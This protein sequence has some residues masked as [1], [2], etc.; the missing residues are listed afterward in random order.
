[1]FCV[2]MLILTQSAVAQV[3]INE[4]IA[5]NDNIIAD[6]YNEYD[7]IIEI[8]NAGNTPI[9]LAGYYFSDDV[10]LPLM[11]QVPTTNAVLTTVPA[12]GYLIF[13]ADNET[14]QGENHLNFKLSSSGESIR[15]TRPDEVTVED[16]FTFPAINTDEAYGRLPDGSNNLSQLLPAS[17]AQ[18]ND[19]SL[20]QTVPPVI[21]PQSGL[22][23]NSQN[24]SISAEP[25]TSIYYT[26]D[27]STPTL[28]SNLYSA[29]FAIDSSQSIKAVAL[30][31][32]FGLSNVTS[33]A[34][35]FNTNT[36]LDILNVSIDPDLLWS[37]SLGIYVTGTNG[38]EGPCSETVPRNWHQNWEYQAEITLFNKNGEVE[39]KEGCGLSISGNC[40]RNVEKKSFAV[41]FKKV[42]GAGTLEHKLFEESEAMEWDGFMLRSGGNHRRNGRINDR[43]AQRVFENQLNIDLQYS[44]PVALYL[45]GE[46]WGLYNI[47]DRSNSGYIKTHHPK[48]DKDSL[49]LI[50][51]PKADGSW[52][53]TIAE[54]VKEGDNIA[55]YDWYDYLVNN[56]LS[57]PANYEYAIS[58]I[59][60]ESFMDYLVTNIYINNNDWPGKNLK[61]WRERIPEGKWRWLM[62][63]LDHFVP[64][65]FARTSNI[66]L[67]DEIMN[68][69]ATNTQRNPVACQPIRQLMANEVFKSEFIQR[70]NTYMATVWDSTRSAAILNEIIAE[71]GN[72]IIPDYDKWGGWDYDTWLSVASNYNDFFEL[73][74]PYMRQMI[75]SV[76]GTSGRFDL[77]LNFDNASNG[78]VALHSNH[79]EVPYSFIAKYHANVPIDIH[80]I[81]NPGYRFSHWEETGNTNSTLYQSFNANTTLTPVFEPALDVVIN[82]IHYHPNDSTNQKEFIEIYNPD[83]KARN[84]SGYEFSEGI[85]FKFPRATTIAPNEYIVIATDVSQYED[86]AYQVFQW[87][88]SKLDNDGENL[89]LQNPIGAIIDSVQYNDGIPWALLADGFGHS[90]ELDYP[91][92]TDNV[93]PADWHASSP[94]DGTPGA[95]NSSPCINS[96]QEI[97]INEINYNSSDSPTPGDWIEL[98]NP[99]STSVDLSDWGF[100]DSENTFDIPA[101]TVLQPDE[102]LVLVE[103]VSLFAG[104]FPH[105]NN[106]THYIGNFDFNLSGGGERISLL[107]NNKCLSDELTY[108]DDMPWDTIP[109]GNGPSL[110]LITTNLDN[111]LPQSWETSSNINSTYGTPARPN[112]PC[113]EQQITVVDTI[114][115]GQATLLRTDL[116]INNTNYTWLAF[117]ATL[118]DANADSTYATWNTPGSYNI[119]L[120]TNYFE[121]TKIYN[122]QVTVLQGCTN[123]DFHAFLE[124]PYDLIGGEMN[125]SS[126]TLHGLLPGQTPTNDL[127]NPT[128]PGHPYSIPPW[129]Y[130]G[131]EGNNWTNANYTDNVVDWVLVSTRTELDKNTQAG[132]AAGLINKDGSIHFWEG[133]P[134]ESIGLDSV[135]VVI[136]HR[137]HMGIMTPQKIPVIN[138][139][140]S[141][142]FRFS[143]SYKDVTSVGQKEILPGVWAMFAGDAD[144]S[145]FPSFDIKGTDKTLWLN[146]NGIF[147]QYMIP[148]FDLNGDVNGADKALW[149]ENNGVSSRVPK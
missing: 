56:D 101:G 80:A 47:R 29:P 134:L 91:L 15:L 143:D 23:T 48:A 71:V 53:W 112:T 70:P 105:L 133:C 73:R 5:S 139:S 126:N 44:R 69:T 21:S 13:W 68:G 94:I 81:P 107:D 6:N 110:S 11:W 54:E 33:T 31:S 2:S 108:D 93:N 76:L 79:F 62:F 9:N 8:Y 86:N 124:G 55:Y 16:S 89:I 127:V 121:C 114:Y 82:E 26:T 72:E 109:D 65:S 99:G 90:L 59:D 123:T 74:P 58:K 61:V 146:N 1:M 141:W 88:K 83:I 39:F 84:L 142:D 122:H 144:Q 10:N 14:A 106:E 130:T 148:D 64:Q 116:L 57:I 128:P 3:Y 4:I 18:S 129:N 34:Y 24:L 137:N 42:F 52:K 32:G 117:G 140:L 51:L 17:P 95:Q 75:D 92:P 20:P 40:S 125:T 7:D 35:I 19:S 43:F 97:V 67:L 119:Q 111:T 98:Y 138:N 135:Y 63:D 147:Q 12:G 30:K 27:G 104:I 22:Y 77:T 36:D 50:S 96:T 60:F 136:E 103:D 131:T 38:I 113:P 115:S 87:E 145:D 100:Y 118:S 37:D 132:I 120:I 25:G 41:A 102:F 46:Y 45:N 149:F 85:C 49:D 78:K 66:I 28:S